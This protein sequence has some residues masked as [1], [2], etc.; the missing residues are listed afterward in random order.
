MLDSP[1]MPYL[2]RPLLKLLSLNN[3]NMCIEE[4]LIN[5]DSVLKKITKFIIRFNN[6]IQKRNNIIP[7]MN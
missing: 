5:I 2:R 4:V 3:N 7:K 6:T 1:R